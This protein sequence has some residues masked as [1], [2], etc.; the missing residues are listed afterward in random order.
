M[1]KQALLTLTLAVHAANLAA[2]TIAWDNPPVMCPEEIFAKGLKCPDF[3][4][5]EDVYADYPDDFSKADIQDWKNNKAADLKVCRNKEVLKRAAVKTGTYS[6]ATLENAWM[7]VDGG[8]NVDEKL[9]AVEEASKK[10]ELPPQILI[11]AMKQESL[12]ASLGISPDGGNFSCGMSQL[13]IQEWC[14]AMNSLTNAEKD[15]FGWPADIECD[16]DALPTNI[17]KPFYDIAV[18][19]LG[20]RPSYQLA[21]SDFKGI[22]AD[23]VTAAF[24]SANKSLQEKRFQAITSFV[25]NC[26][27]IP[28]SIN[29]KAKT[30]RGL[31]DH[32]VPSKLKEQELYAPGKT[33]NRACRSPYTSK[34]YPLNTGWLLAV[35]MYNAGP[36]QAKVVEYYFQTKSDSLPAMNPLDLIEALHWG[37]KWKPGT[38]S[39]VF[40]NMDSDSKPGKKGWFKKNDSNEFTQ[41]W[42]K[43]CIVQRHVARV[44]QHVTLPAESIAKSLEVGGCTATGVPQYRQNSSGIKN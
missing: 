11:G 26:Q 44:I 16:S 28:L 33:F 27:N 14:Q 31:Y 30:L 5:V 4:N 15:S 43:S 3:S 39:L 17:V 2:A 6:P 13:N 22:T 19:N 20:T 25:N 42:F 35:A 23:Q 1:L 34:F 24:P 32:F 18:K 40:T 12:M 37:G 38:D 9:K 36:Q 7:I 10:Y 8:N 41:S 21:A 29:F